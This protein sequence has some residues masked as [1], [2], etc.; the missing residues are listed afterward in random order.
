MNG[1]GLYYN[2]YFQKFEKKSNAKMKNKYLITRPLFYFF[3]NIKLFAELHITFTEALQVI[4]PFTKI[5][6]KAS[7]GK[8]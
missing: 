4:L 1:V 7:M 8:Q 3:N 5:R 2:K 6:D